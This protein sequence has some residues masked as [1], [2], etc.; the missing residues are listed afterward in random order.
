M[1][2]WVF[3]VLVGSLLYLHRRRTVWSG[4]V[5]GLALITTMYQGSYFGMLGALVGVVF[6][7]VEFVQARSWHER[8]WLITLADVAIVVALIAFLP[9]LIA[10]HYDREA[11]AAV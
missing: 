1:H 6:L 4:V 2:A 5:V 9:A 11:V 3:A 10:W 7:A 8:L